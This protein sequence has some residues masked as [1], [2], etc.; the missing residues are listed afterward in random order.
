[1]GE[2]G[3]SMRSLL[4]PISDNHP[5]FMMP[6]HVTFLME[7]DML[8]LCCVKLLL[9]LVYVRSKIIYAKVSDHIDS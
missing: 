9:V 1:M 8:V 5:S 2:A 3:L 4:L 7:Y 6:G